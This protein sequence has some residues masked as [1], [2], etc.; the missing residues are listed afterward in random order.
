V[1][2]RTLNDLR[3]ELHQIAADMRRPALS[4][5]R[6]VADRLSKLLIESTLLL[7]EAQQPKPPL[8]V[9][10][11][12]PQPG[13]K[14]RGRVLTTAFAMVPGTRMGEIW[15]LV[16]IVAGMPLQTWRASDCTHVE[17]DK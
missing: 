10:H 15:L 3:A 13:G 2:I 9:E 12:T 11:T 6:P 16:E 8:L 5:E 4:F 7:A 17:D 1:S 14:Q